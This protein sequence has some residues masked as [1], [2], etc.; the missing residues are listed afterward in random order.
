[1]SENGELILTNDDKRYLSKPNG[2]L[3]LISSSDFGIATYKN[4]SWYIIN[5]KSLFMLS[6]T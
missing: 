4:G 5:N 6:T 3:L 2:E 1:M